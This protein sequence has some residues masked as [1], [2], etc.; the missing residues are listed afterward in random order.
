MKYEKQP[1]DPFKNITY[2]STK[3]EEFTLFMSDDTKEYP[4]KVE[5]VG[6]TNPDKDYFIARKHP[7][8]F[9]IEYVMDGKGYVEVDGQK[10]EVFADSV[11]ILPPGIKHSYGADKHTPYRKVWIN[12]FSS[13]LIDFMASYGLKNKIVFHNSNCKEYFAELLNIARDRPF[14][15][16]YNIDVSRVIFNLL[17]TL[18]KQIVGQENNSSYIALKAKQELDSSIYRKMNVEKLCESLTVSKSQ[19]TREFKKHFSVTPY[20]YLLNKKIN[21]AKQLLLLT[22]MKVQ[23]ISDALCFSDEYNFSNVF[24]SK[25]GQSPF[26]FRKVGKGGEQ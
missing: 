22:N 11:Y 7:H 1:V 4:I 2:G 10:Y 19:L 12:C 9:V 17:F 18:S 14:N 21:V 25:V 20:Q 13:I 23:E 16:D 8:Y 26:A 3:E 6:I 24:K 5:S 15:E